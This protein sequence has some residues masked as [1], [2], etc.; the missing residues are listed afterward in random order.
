MEGTVIT[1][2]E[3]I[4][5]FIPAGECAVMMANGLA[6]NTSVSCIQVKWN[7]VEARLDPD[8]AIYSVLATALQSNSTLRKLSFEIF[9]SLADDEVNIEQDWSSIGAQVPVSTSV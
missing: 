9:L 8:P 5:C 1:K 7:V 4:H 6:R 2:L 3:C